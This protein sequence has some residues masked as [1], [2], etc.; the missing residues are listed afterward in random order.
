MQ[1]AVV[2]LALYSIRA[3]CSTPL[4]PWSIGMRSPLARPGGRTAIMPFME[5]D[6]EHAFDADTAVL[7]AGFAF[8]AYNEP[9][10]RDARWE[11]GADGCDVA[12]MSEAF[13]HECYAGR[14]EVRLCE[15]KELPKKQELTQT[16]LSGGDNDPYVVFALNEEI[17]PY[18]TGPKEGAVAIERAVDTARSSTVWS[19]DSTRRQL[20]EG[21]AQWGEGETFY[22]Y[23]KDPRCAQLALTVFDEEVLKDDIVL[24]AASVRLRSLLNFEGATEKQRSW[25][26]WVPLSWRPEEAVDKAALMGAVAG[27]M[28][29]GP[30]GAA[31]GGLLGNMIK[32]PVQG[33]V[34]LHLKYMPLNSESLCTESGGKEAAASS[35]VVSA[36]GGNK[37]VI[38]NRAAPRGASEGVDWS[39]LSK[40]VGTIG[41][42]END[43]YELCCF[44]THNATSTQAAL[45]RDR[46]QRQLV[47]AFRGTSD[48]LD[49]LTD[50][51][52]LQ[53]PF[54]F[55]EDSRS[56]DDT[57]LV[58][59]GFFASAKAVNRRLKELVLA[60]CA[61]TPGE[62]EVLVTG[63]SL[64]GALATLTTPELVGGV[65]TTRGFKPRA[66][67]GWVGAVVR[68][69]QEALVARPT[70][71]RVRLYTFGAPRVGNTDFARY[72][73]SL[74]LEAFRIVNGLDIVARLPRHRNSAGA[75]LDYE[76]CG[77]TVL[78]DAAAEGQRFWVEGESEDAVCPLREASPLAN[79][80]GSQR[81]L[82]D[83][84]QAALAAASTAWERMEGV[85]P[86]SLSRS[87]AAAA[88]ELGKAGDAIATRIE[89]MSPL[90]A[91]SVLGLDDK[92]V[93]AE[94][95]LM[96]ALLSGSAIVHHLEPSYFDGMRRALDAAADDV[97]GREAIG[98][99]DSWLA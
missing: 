6:T 83:V 78:V 41:V 35:E 87:I 48:P 81:I 72:F 47:L 2:M 9:A 84:S 39:E 74:G 31:A 30:V 51:N 46:A 77:R 97:D 88:G 68:A 80:F 20:R 5:E 40:R 52:L 75:V 50:V 3:E 61:G 94:V 49:L 64:G 33:S 99:S 1:N 93:E 62:W 32:K 28:I 57:R 66:D 29:G 21:A 44:V 60:A 69:A 27:G 43:A 23:V 7:L 10:P 76:H 95:R 92:F 11:R 36:T 15:A 73:D 17:S 34:R 26:G 91:V 70:L 86:Q 18:G 67:D 79:P 58:H 37:C 38:A 59:A 19:R 13:A 89:S 63:H 54:E 45:W 4:R 90:E 71:A 16:I 85:G 56:S 42:D 8:E 55:R 12:F 98:S 53:T 24:G 22:L 82:G 96:E 25:S 14:L 65:D